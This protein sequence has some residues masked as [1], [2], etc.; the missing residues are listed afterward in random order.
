MRRKKR[1]QNQDYKKYLPKNSSQVFNKTFTRDLWKNEHLHP[2]IGC[3]NEK[4]AG[5]W[6]YKRPEVLAGFRKWE[7]DLLQYIHE[8]QAESQR[9]LREYVYQEYHQN[10]YPHQHTHKIVNHLTLPRKRIRQEA[11]DEIE[12]DLNF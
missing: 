9:Q 10:Q 11:H 8:L 6:F 12:V 2:I 5:E 4:E 1:M 3:K 7:N